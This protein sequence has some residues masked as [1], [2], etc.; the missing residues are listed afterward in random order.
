MWLNLI[1]AMIILLPGVWDCFLFPLLVIQLPLIS[2]SFPFSRHP[3]YLI[4][5]LADV[6]VTILIVYW[7]EN[8]CTHFRSPNDIERIKYLIKLHLPFTKFLNAIRN[9]GDSLK[10]VF[11]KRQR[12][13]TYIKL[14]IEFNQRKFFKK[15][16]VKTS[17]KMNVIIIWDSSSSVHFGEV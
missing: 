11:M 15:S 16:G 9:G 6:V 13:S 1:L 8:V 3:S 2:L 12:E 17:R 10:A 4:I 7:N 5:G 14:P